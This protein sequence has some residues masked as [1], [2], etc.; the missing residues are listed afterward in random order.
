MDLYN[1]Q[2]PFGDP[3]LL[4]SSFINNPVTKSYEIGII[5]HYIDQSVLWNQIKDNKNI[6]FINIL[7]SI[8]TIIEEIRKCNFVYSSSLHGLVLCDSYNIPNSWIKLTNNIIGDDTKF[9]DY[10]MSV[11]RETKFLD[12]RSTGFIYPNNIGDQ[13]GNYSKLEVINNVY[14]LKEIIW[15]TCPFSTKELK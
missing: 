7:D 1:I 11:G 10:L 12:F 13:I 15:K 8:E 9:L 5:P 3:G 4:V 6:H 2:V 14:T